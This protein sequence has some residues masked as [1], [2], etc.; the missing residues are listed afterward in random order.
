[1]TLPHLHQT[2]NTV[3]VKSPTCERRLMNLLFYKTH[4][5]TTAFDVAISFIHMEEKKLKEHDHEMQDQ[6]PHVSPFFES[7]YMMEAGHNTMSRASNIYICIYIYSYKY[8]STYTLHS[9]IKVIGG[10]EGEG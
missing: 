4:Q 10:G 5:H 3:I 8:A 2:E 9:E 6:S 1:M 7:S